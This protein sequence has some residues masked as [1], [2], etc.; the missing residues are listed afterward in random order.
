MDYRK[1]SQPIKDFEK[2][3]LKNKKQFVLVVLLVSL[4]LPAGKEAEAKEEDIPVALEP[5][6]EK[7]DG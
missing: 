4:K 5:T 2:T 7:Q 3:A 1:I 6:R